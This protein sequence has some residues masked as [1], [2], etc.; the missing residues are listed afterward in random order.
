MYI[1]IL[2]AHI[3]N[4]S[5]KTKCSVKLLTEEVQY[6]YLFVKAA[7]P[8]NLEENQLHNLATATIDI[9]VTVLLSTPLK[10]SGFI[11]CNQL[12]WKRHPNSILNNEKVGKAQ[13]SIFNISNMK[14]LGNLTY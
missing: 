11:E 3:R 2:V 7:G 5:I 14:H 1:T 9:Q 4:V 10:M 13:S 12:E 8:E 6:L